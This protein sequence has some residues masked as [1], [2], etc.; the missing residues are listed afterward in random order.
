MPPQR[1]F[2]LSMVRGK[3]CTARNFLQLDQPSEESGYAIP[4]PPSQPA[5]PV[6]Q[7]VV[8][9]PVAGSINPANASGF[10]EQNSSNLS[11]PGCQAAV[12]IELGRTIIRLVTNHHFKWWFDLAPLGAF[13]TCT[14]KGQVLQALLLAA[15]KKRLPHYLLLLFLLIALLYI[16]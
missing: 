15:A 12:E 4:D 14:P 7:E 11:L 13:I 2:R 16:S 5:V 9:L 1:P 10:E 3:R 8:N 6:V